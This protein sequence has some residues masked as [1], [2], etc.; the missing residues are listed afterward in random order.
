MEPSGNEGSSAQDNRLEGWK[1]IAAYLKHSERTVRRWEATEALP[2]RRHLH[3]QRGSVYAFRTELDTWRDGRSQRPTP[4]QP[5]APNVES[6]PHNRK[7]FWALLTLAA[8][9]AGLLAY[10][11]VPIRRPDPLTVPITS[12]LGNEL[13]PSF[14]PDGL[15]IAFT[16]TGAR[17]DNHD[18]YVRP[19]G[20][21]RPVRLTSDPAEEFGPAWSP[22]GRTIAFLR[23]ASANQIQIVTIPAAG[24]PSRVLGEFHS[25]PRMFSK[26][27]TRFLA[28]RPGSRQLTVAGRNSPDEPHSLWTIDDNGNR[29]RLTTPPATATFGDMNPAYAPD[30]RKLVF[31]RGNTRFT[32]EL[33]LVPLSDDGLPATDP[34]LIVQGLASANTPVWVGDRRIVFHRF[35]T[36]LWTLSLPGNH[37]QPLGFGRWWAGMPAFSSH[38]NRLVYADGGH[39]LNIW[40]LDLVAPSRLAGKPRRAVA[41]TRGEFAAAV[42]PDGRQLAFASDRSGNNEI[43]ISDIEGQNATQLTALPGRSAGEPRWSPDGRWIAFESRQEGRADVF[44]MRADGS[45]VRQLTTHRAD[46][47]WVNWSRDGAWLYFSSNRTGTWDVWKTHWETGREV[48][49]TTGGGLGAAESR[50]GRYLYYVKTEHSN[51]SFGFLW[52]AP[53]QG[54][55]EEPLLT[56]FKISYTDFAVLDDA[57]YFI[58]D[59]QGFGRNALFLLQLGSGTVTRITNLADTFVG[60]LTITPD[61][62]RIL[63]TVAEEKG[64]DLVAVENF[65]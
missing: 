18:I 58:S 39:D 52:R 54:G 29:R 1:E 8:G 62:R 46:D 63:Y 49:V 36:G 10:E 28:W 19:L 33:N 5:A 45:S 15:Q 59:D 21:D 37:A 26:Y 60:Y 24:G 23:V 34:N 9:G 42:S 32:S 47:L 64:Y 4:N 38:G 20:Q 51:S 65:R 16:W 40:S 13:D 43:W 30:G 12:Y 22:D 57:V 7:R 3:E 50:D 41:S 17:Q 11:F 6:H 48:R 55:R 2:V 14:S 56:A 44:A 61:R 35:F 53:V 31:T 25:E 27:R